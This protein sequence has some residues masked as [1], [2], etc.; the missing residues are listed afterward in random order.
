MG[1]IEN[2][3]DDLKGKAKE[4]AG[5]LTGN[6]SLENEGKA[7]QVKSD[8]RSAV[9]NAGE[10]IKDAVHDAGE[11]V[12]DVANKVIGSFKKDDA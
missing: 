10:H 8:V 12:K 7:D 9:E 1:D 3:F 11:A 4:T 2:T 6:E 5:D